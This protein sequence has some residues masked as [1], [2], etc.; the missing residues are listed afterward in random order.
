MSAPRFPRP[1]G[2]PAAIAAVG[3]SLQGKGDGWER[4]HQGLDAV[5]DRLI[6]R[7]HSP[8]A[9]LPAK[10]LLDMAEVAV[11]YRLLVVGAGQEFVKFAQD[12]DE[13]QRAVDRLQQEADRLHAEARAYADTL[14]G[15]ARRQMA[16]NE[17][18]EYGYSE[19]RKQYHRVIDEL[20]A[21]ATLLSDYLVRASS[22]VQKTLD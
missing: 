12:L 5:A 17:E 1:E 7:W 14:T 15:A 10:S 2:D 13:A 8:V 20:A 9:Q 16:Y 18:T 21:N 4:M 22:D 3:Q 19:L 11:A 6:D